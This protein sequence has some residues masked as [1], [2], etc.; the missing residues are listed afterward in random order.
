M[1][2]IVN[3]PKKIQKKHILNF[4]FKKSYAEGASKAEL[5][6]LDNTIKK[7]YVPKIIL[8][9]LNHINAAIRRHKRN[10]RAS[11]SF[12]LG[13][14]LMSPEN[15]YTLSFSDEHLQTAYYDHDNYRYY[16]QKAGAYHIDVFVLWH[17]LIGLTLQGQ[18]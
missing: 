12:L 18:S 7:T 13:T 17:M 8:K 5:N 6:D 14:T 11:S 10:L 2:H 9:L 15:W 3:R 16:S 4:P 1:P